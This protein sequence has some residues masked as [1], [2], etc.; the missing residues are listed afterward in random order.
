[1]MR[2]HDDCALQSMTNSG[3][4]KQSKMV[5]CIHFEN[6]PCQSQRFLTITLPPADHGA[7]WL[8]QRCQA[9]DLEKIAFKTPAYSNIAVKRAHRRLA[10]DSV[11]SHP[12]L[13][14]AVLYLDDKL[15]MSDEDHR[16][17]YFTDDLLAALPDR[18]RPHQCFTANVKP[19]VVRDLQTRGLV[20]VHHGCVCVLLQRYAST[21]VYRRLSCFIHD[22][23][24]LRLLRWSRAGVS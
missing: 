14:P 6:V 15:P 2:K 5:T 1:M 10:I 7:A 24:R 23:I 9:T 16:E 3:D 18:V 8:C 20:N 19:D 17:T 4:D 11:A 12:A 21:I 13:R 22:D